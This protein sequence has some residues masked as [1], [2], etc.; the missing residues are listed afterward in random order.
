MA[1][2]AKNATPGEVCP[3]M[4]DAAGAVVIST[5]ESSLF[6]FFFVLFNVT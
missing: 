4:S 6:I 3:L 2:S 5:D 1:T